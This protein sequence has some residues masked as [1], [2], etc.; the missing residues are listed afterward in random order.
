M[1]PEFAAYKDQLR[2]VALP[3]RLGGLLGVMIGCALLI[4]STKFPGAALVPLGFVALG[5]GWGVTGYAIWLRT[6]WAKANPF[7]GQR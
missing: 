6:Q 3:L 2:A 4:A 5:L 1:T 7:V